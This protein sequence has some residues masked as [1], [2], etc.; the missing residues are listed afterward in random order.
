M[1][2]SPITERK[3]RFALVGCGRISK[4][5]FAAI[6][7]HADRAEIVEV[8]DT[9]EP[10]LAAAVEATGAKA[11][12]SLTELLAHGTADAVILASPSGLHPPQA[13]EVPTQAVT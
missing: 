13:I 12:S 6:A 5:R 10:C 2:P 3:I 11:Y 8:C 1:S 9:H 4:D 7:R